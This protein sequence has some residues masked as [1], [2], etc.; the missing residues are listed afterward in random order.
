M[1]GGL[2]SGAG[3]EGGGIL[4][5]LT[6]LLGGGGGGGGGQGTDVL[7]GFIKMFQTLQQENGVQTVAQMAAEK[8][9]PPKS[10]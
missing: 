5:G 7:G 6:G 2:E 8:G 10:I 1:S 3:G 9:T 4:S